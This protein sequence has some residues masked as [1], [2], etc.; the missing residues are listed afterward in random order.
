MANLTFFIDYFKHYLSAKTRHGIHSPFVYTLVDKVIYDFSPKQ[1]NAALEGQRKRLRSD[2]RQIEVTDLGAGSMLEKS[3][4]R[5]I[6][7]IA[8]NALKPARVAQLLARLAS[9]LEPKTIIELGTCL[10]ITTSY[11]AKASKQSRIYTA[12]GCPQ[13]A[14]VARETFEQLQVTDQITLRVGNFD[15][16]LPEI[17][18][19]LGTVAFLFIDGNHTYEATMNYF[20]TALGHID[21]NSVL[22]FDDI[23]WSE[24]MKR[25]WADIKAHPSVT[26]SIDL[27]YI[28]LVFFRKDREKEHFK[29][30]FG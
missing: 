14:L 20:E 24:G 9:Y 25:A 1:Y 10:G 21:E 26:L 3:N 29:I 12:E 4:E 11:L 8:K 16:L 27:F 17:L 30:K 19:H 15:E 7:Q 28:G 6:S 23:Y 22:I 18:Q 5:T 2:Q 13:T